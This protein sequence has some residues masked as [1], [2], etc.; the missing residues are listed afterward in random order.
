[1]PSRSTTTQRCEG[2]WT[3]GD[4][5]P[6][7]RGANA[8]SSCWTMSPWLAIRSSPAGPP[9]LPWKLSYGGHPSPASPPSP[10]LR[11]GHAVAAVS[12]RSGGG[13]RAKDGAAPRYCPGTSR[14][15]AGRATSTP[16]RRER[17]AAPSGFEPES[18]RSERRILPVRRQGRTSF[19]YGPGDGTR[20][21]FLCLDKAAS[22][23][24]RPRREWIRGVRMAGRRGAAPRCRVLETPP[25][26]GP[27]PK[28][29][30]KPE[31]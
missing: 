16:E 9:S 31:A 22:R 18:R 15:S 1:M 2:W 13:R 30:L 6:D 10:R 19:S 3:H 7:F 28:N 21:H 4:L 5:H 23:L 25:V 8:A 20:T 14:S 17:L 27:Q 29:S 11:R 26:A 12:D 24:L